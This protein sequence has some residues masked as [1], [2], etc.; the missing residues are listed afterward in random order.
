MPDIR[1]FL[2]RGLAASVLTFSL[3]LP[4][5]GPAHA[6][7]TKAKQ[8]ILLDFETG[9]VLMEKDARTRMYPASMS[10]I[11]TVY[12]AF[13]KL[14]EGRLSMDDEIPVSEK[15]WRKGGSKMFIEVGDRIRVED[16][17]RGII[18]QSGNDASIA[19]AEALAGTEDAFADLMTQ[20]ARDIGMTD[21]QFRNATGWPDPDH[22]VTAYDLAVLAQRLVADFPQYYHF[23]KEKEFTWNGI[24]QGNRNPLLYRPGLGADGIKTGHTEAS[25]YG[26]A[27]SAIRGDHRLIAVVNGLDSVKARGTEAEK[28]LEWGFRNFENRTLFKA[29]ETVE[30]AGVWLGVEDTVPLVT[31]ED[32]RLTLP[33]GK[34]A[35][36]SAVVRYEGPLPAPI[37][38]GAQVATLTV[39]A[40]D[41]D[42]IEIPLYAQRSIE[43]LGFLGRIVAAAETLIFGAVQ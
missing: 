38:E 14:V 41:L 35:D 42:P 7:E 43:K 8:A 1:S 13:Q 37:A 40:Q 34:S 2:R 11:M 15:A 21:S 36:M 30:E 3:A 9:T 18:I 26:L 22:Y 12:I 24:K 28:L 25:G 32:V 39:T 33:R 29:G 20:T 19:L 6:L 16:I 10:K 17:L 5:S 23:Y 31:R 4:F 27:A